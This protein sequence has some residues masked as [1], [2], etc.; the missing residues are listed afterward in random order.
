MVINVE[1]K[2]ISLN[3]FK[4][5]MKDFY[6][7]VLENESYETKEH[8]HDC[9]QIVICKHGSL[10][11]KVNKDKGK[12]LRGD[13]FIVPPNVCHRLT[14]G[15]SKTVYYNI[16]FSKDIF[17]DK[18]PYWEMITEL[19]G[20]LES[21]HRIIPKITPMYEDIYLCESARGKMR[22][23]FQ[24]VRP[25]REEIIFNCLTVMLSLIARMY[26]KLDS[27]TIPEATKKN[28]R[29]NQCIFYADSHYDE[30]IPLEKIV[31]MSAMSRASF[32]S[33]F[34]EMT[35]MTFNEYLNKKRIER[36]QA[37]IRDGEDLSAC[38]FKSGF[39]EISTFYRNFVKFTG[40]SPSE[41]KRICEKER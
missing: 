3:D 7:E 21:G 20:N 12:L 17:A 15:E 39:K 26:V 16:S 24:D 2:I 8:F 41:Y 38:A 37:L 19:L 9:F 25:G 28:Q 18:H 31:K 32:C 27:D 36:T 5:N 4:S 10:I 14:V 11:H 1:K 22:I 35:G 23:E 6:I 33:M 30:P 29:M 13:I 34:K 40:Y